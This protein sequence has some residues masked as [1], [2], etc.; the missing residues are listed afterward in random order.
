MFWE[1]FLAGTTI[2]F[3]IAGVLFA[4]QA[5]L[6]SRTPQAAIAWMMAL[7]LFPY[8]AIP[9]FLVFGQSRFSGYVLAGTGVSPALDEALKH[10]QTALEPHRSGFEEKY[11]DSVGLTERLVRLPVTTGNDA[12]L[13]IDGAGTFEA[14]SEAIDSAES[15]ILIQFFIVHDDELGR[16]IKAHLLAA[17]SRGV[18]IHMLID[19]VGS[20]RLPAAYREE[21]RAAGVHLRTFVTN[22]DRG[23][24]FRINFRNHRKLVVT[25]GRHGFVGGLNV[26]DEYMGRDPKFGPWRDTFLQLEGPV[27]QALQIPF[28]EDWLFTT[29]EVLDLPWQVHPAPRNFAA[30][31]IPGGPTTA[32]NTCPASLL[33]VIRSARTRLWLASPYFV[34]DSALLTAIAHASLRGVEVRLLLPQHPDHILPWLSSF[35]FYPKLRA[36]NVQV[37]RYQDGFMHQKV[38]LADD[39]L[40]VVGSINLDYRSFMLNFELS[41]AVASAEFTR[42]VEAMFERDFAASKPDDMLAYENGGLLFRLRCR[43]AALVSPQQ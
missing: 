2:A 39:D 11:E 34:P 29:G 20:R 25:D 31:T 28:L 30:C 10:A 43:L 21:L 42:E 24:R 7:A 18:E 37:W 41:V 22:R 8:G 3:H 35:T 12:R 15:F 13:L 4:L 33:E 17:R 27:V 1:L 26:G 9:L 16:E 14:I 32:W 6:I 23:K 38:I 40:A 5:I 19:Q 36:A